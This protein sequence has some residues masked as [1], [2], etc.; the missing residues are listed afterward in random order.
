MIQNDGGAYERAKEQAAWQKMVPPRNRNDYN[1]SVPNSKKQTATRGK[2]ARTGW[3]LPT[4]TVLWMLYLLGNDH[5]AAAIIMGLVMG[6]MIYSKEE[7][8]KHD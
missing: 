5:F 7:P 6:V 3:I 8:V 1:V 2:R 4:V